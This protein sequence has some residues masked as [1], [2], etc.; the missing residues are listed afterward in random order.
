LLSHKEKT[1]KKAKEKESTK[2]NNEKG[3]GREGK[4]NNSGV[5][6]NVLP[7]RY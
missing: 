1:K 4:Q 6:I 5:L 2:R 7:L 3:K